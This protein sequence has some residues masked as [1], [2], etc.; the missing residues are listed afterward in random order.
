MGIFFHLFRVQVTLPQSKTITK[1]D[2]VVILETFWDEID[3]ELIKNTLIDS[4]LKYFLFNQK[5]AH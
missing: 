4:I 3:E 1:R 5:E 2:A